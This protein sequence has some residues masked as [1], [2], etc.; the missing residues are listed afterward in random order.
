MF[1]TIR[2]F[3]RMEL[4]NLYG[5]NVLRFTKNKK[6]RQKALAMALLWI[7]LAAMIVF[8]L[9][10]LSYS[11]VLLDLQDIIP[12]YLAFLS[13]LIIFVFSILKAGAVLFRERGYGML[14]SLPVHQSCLV[15][16]RFLRM[17]VEELVLALLIYLPG[18]AVYGFFVHPGISFYLCGILSALLIPLPPLAASA[19]IGAFV[20]GISSRMKHKSLVAAGLSVI[21]V[22]AVLFFSSRLS[23]LEGITVSQLQD[24]SVFLK[25]IFGK[26][27]PPALWLGQ[28]TVQGSFLKLLACTCGFGLVFAGIISLVTV[29]FHP[30]CRNLY[31]ASARHDYHMQS[32]KTHSVMTSLCRREFRHYFSSGVYLTNTIISPILGTIM[33]GIVFFKGMD[34][35]QAPLEAQLSIS[36]NLSALIPIAAA[37]IMSLMPTTCVSIS[38]EGKY[39]WI[40]RSLP[41]SAKMILNAKLLMYLILLLPF[42]ILTE[43]FLIAAIRPYGMELLW[44][45]LLPAAFALFSGVF[46]L[47]VNLHFPVLN[48]ENEVSV[49]KQSASSGFGALCS[50]ILALLCILGAVLIPPQL[51]VLWQPT[52]C[53]LIFAAA[54]ILYHRIL[55]KNANFPTLKE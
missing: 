55:R 8:Y 3:V 18:L 54:A 46:G 45:I 24:L 47:A 38:I 42:Y 19:F 39:W 40:T 27:Y 43:F 21:F 53:L 36:I 48:W 4:C 17:Y 13:S 23:S 2:P 26:I 52:V 37:G 29:F 20:T 50:M 33:A 34:A 12:T 49:V 51:S 28:A 7:L 30:V 16:S 15:L 31:A 1:K 11:L 6:A 5:L 44:M 22:L 41:L 10:A 14:C 32:L 9:S 35:L 25:N